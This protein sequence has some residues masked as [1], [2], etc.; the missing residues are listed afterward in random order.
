MFKHYLK[1]AWRSIIRSSGFSLLGMVGFAG[2]MSLGMLVI[3]L[4]LDQ[5]SYDQFH[6]NSDRIYRINTLAIRQD[7]STESY[8]STTLALSRQIKQMQ[9]GFDNVVGLDQRLIVDVRNGDITLPLRGYFVDE[10]FFEVFGFQLES[11]NEKS[12]LNDPKSVFISEA[13]ASAL[14]GIKAAIGQTVSLGDWGDFVVGGILK[15]PTGK[16]HLEFDVLIPMKALVMLEKQ[17]K[18]APLTDDWSSIY[19]GFV[20][21]KVLEGISIDK[22]QKQINRFSKVAFSG[23][24]LESRDKSYEFFLQPLN[25]ITPGPELSNQIGRAIPRTFIRLL[26]IF[27]VIILILAILN[28]ASLTL[29]IWLKRIKEVGV[30][31]STGA[32]ANHV[33]YQFMCEAIIFIFMALIFSCIFLQL[34]NMFFL[35]LNLSRQ[36]DVDLSLTPWKLVSFI[37]FA[38][39]VAI[40]SGILPAY[41]LAR[42]KPVNMFRAS[43]LNVL[44]G[45]STFRKL[46]TVFQFS[47]AIIFMVVVLMLNR[48]MEYMLKANYGIKEENIFNLYLNGNERNHLI[49]EIIKIPG[50]KSIGS[51]SHSLG[52]YSD[53]S[54]DYWIKPGTD[55]IRVRDFSVDNAYMENLDIQLIAGS[56]FTQQNT[57]NE[58]IINESALGLLG[59]PIAA[60][61]INQVISGSDSTPLRIAGVVRDFHFR[62]FDYAIE[63]LFLRNDPKRFTILSIAIE[64]SAKYSFDKEIRTLWK[65]M[66]PVHPIQFVPMIEE[67]DEAYV[68][69]GYID[70]TKIVG[71]V[72][73]LIISIAV[74]GLFG[75]VMYTLE[76]RVKEIGIRKVVGADVFQ[77]IFLVTRSYYLLIGMGIIIGAPIGFLFSK[78]ILSDFPNLVSGNG[79]SVLTSVIIVFVIGLVVVLSQTIKAAIANPVKSLRTE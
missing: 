29:A 57:N 66:D 55:A 42:T 2:A 48:Q 64:P 40:L 9:I 36:F 45:P 7:G 37:F 14:F 79:W 31:K 74:L 59:I 12:C 16:S 1:T 46:L 4:V 75:F 23:K 24:K 65:S 33:F 39:V 17:G 47:F 56:F 77:I 19:N 10:H 60:N 28:Y 30:R 71:Y 63:P 44:S 38:L 43:F 49:N 58:V 73:F 18:V 52:T 78:L 76:F 11:G 32:T 13:K 25:G 6:Q 20:Y 51:V 35:Q 5:Y 27:S 3:S 34:L 50:V 62:P 61:A 68:R 26:I 22:I 54:G 8:A 15:K 67:I 72:S 70:L 21:V 41:Y 69:S 53:G